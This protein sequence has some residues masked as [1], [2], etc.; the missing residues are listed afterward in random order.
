MAKYS[1][2]GISFPKLFM[3]KRGTSPVFYVSKI[4]DIRELGSGVTVSR[5]AYFDE[6]GEAYDGLVKQLDRLC[7]RQN[8]SLGLVTSQANGVH[9][10][11]DHHVLSFMK[12]FDPTLADDD[13]DNFYMEREWRIRGG[14]RFTLND[15]VRIT[16]PGRFEERFR[17]DLPD[18][19]GP[20]EKVED[21]ST[22]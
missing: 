9:H 22:Y 3:V 13:P 2:F 6:M 1:E 11:L 4:G 7:L 10:L 20:I 15:V 14:L 21:V 17:S 19:C 5:D 18:Y 16:V 12:F 8:P